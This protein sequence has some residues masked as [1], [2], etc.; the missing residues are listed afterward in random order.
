MKEER[1]AKDEG[2]QPL[3][4]P[5]PDSG[6]DERPLARLGIA[7][8][9]DLLDDIRTIK[10]MSHP[11]IPGGATFWAI[12]VHFCFRHASVTEM[13]YWSLRLGFNIVPRMAGDYLYVQDM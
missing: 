11:T 4:P 8:P 3:A 12:D 6:Y 10:S 5:P 1:E 2:K 7:F 9:R 13:E